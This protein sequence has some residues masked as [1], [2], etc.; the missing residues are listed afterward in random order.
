MS[1]SPPYGEP[2]RRAGRGWGSQE[3][4][5]DGSTSVTTASL[6][7]CVGQGVGSRHA[8]YVGGGEYHTL[9][10]P[11]HYHYGTDGQQ[12]HGDGESHR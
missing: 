7:L 9:P 1:V 3:C 11:G 6:G 12:E 10:H 2:L 8:H 5:D 4:E